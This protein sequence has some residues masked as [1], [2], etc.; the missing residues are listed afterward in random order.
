MER[1]SVMAM[2][3]Q[4]LYC[5]WDTTKTSLVSLFAIVALDSAPAKIWPCM[6]G[7][8]LGLVAPCTVV[9]NNICFFIWSDSSM[10]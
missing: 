1:I 5:Y 10:G 7:R 6:F 8:T 2:L 9:M 3:T 4:E